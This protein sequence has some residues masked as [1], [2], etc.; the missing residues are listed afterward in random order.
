MPPR[1]YVNP[2]NGYLKC[3][4]CK[5]EKKPED[6]YFRADLR[7]NRYSSCKNC[8]NVLQRIAYANGQ[9]IAQRWR[10]IKKH[11][12]ITETEYN[13]IL[14][15][16]NHQCALCFKPWKSNFNIDHD[17]AHHLD[18]EIG[19]PS[20]V[21]GILCKTCN[22]RNLPWVEKFPHL[23]NDFV[24]QYLTT[25]PLAPSVEAALAA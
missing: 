8:F 22:H 11:F 9:N 15:K 2:E 1:R 21:R 7:N 24:K 5:V 4:K 19:C 13:C 25:R 12:G 18:K 10:R 17:H 6:F 20:C 16:Q 3:S 23:Q 14:L